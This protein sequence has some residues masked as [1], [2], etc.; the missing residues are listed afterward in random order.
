M[1]KRKRTQKQKV[2]EYEQARLKR[3]KLAKRSPSEIA[4]EQE[5]RYGEDV[6]Y[7]KKRCTSCKERKHLNEFHK[8]KSLSDGLHCSCKVCHCKK[9]KMVREAISGTKVGK[10]CENCGYNTDVRALDFAHY[11]RDTKARSSSGK[12]I[13][14][15]GF[16]SLTKFFQESPFLHLLCCNCHADET[17]RETKEISE[18]KFPIAQRSVRGIA[19]LERHQAKAQ[20]IHQEKLKRSKCNRCNLLVTTDTFHCFDF[21]H[22]PGVDKIANVSR[23]A[24]R[25]A[26]DAVIIAE[27][28]KC[29]LLCKCCHRIV[30]LDRLTKATRLVQ[31]RLDVQSNGSVDVVL[32]PNP[33][34][35][36]KKRCRRRAAEEQKVELNDINKYIVKDIGSRVAVSWIKEK[37]GFLRG[38]VTLN[39][40]LQGFGFAVESSYTITNKRSRTPMVL[41]FRPN[42]DGKKTAASEEQMSTDE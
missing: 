23:L 29:Q 9:T 33:K 15:S 21:D 10:C 31:V 38:V 17:V 20:V 11:T 22:L 2:S 32:A 12:P 7:Q 24:A 13:Q 36:K 28:N 34:E 18:Q 40:I 4:R 39:K 30:T 14:P 35:S 41:N 6:R 27:M 26:P 37:I 1:G 8:N 19:E 25:V 3:R 16:M 5:R 42:C